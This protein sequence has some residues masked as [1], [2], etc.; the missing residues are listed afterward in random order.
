[1]RDPEH[2]SNICKA[3]K[4]HD[5]QIRFGHEGEGMEHEEYKQGVDHIEFK[6]W[7]KKGHGL[8]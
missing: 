8:Y 5:H 2:A 1:M 3:F 7:T 6:Q 4:N